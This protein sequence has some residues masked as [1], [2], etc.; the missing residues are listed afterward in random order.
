VEFDASLSG[1]A[2]ADAI[3][4]VEASIRAA[5]PFRSIIYI[6]P[7]FYEASQDSRLASEPGDD[8]ETPSR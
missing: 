3:D 7:D 8:A 4:E 6:E 1:Q 2:L 5:V